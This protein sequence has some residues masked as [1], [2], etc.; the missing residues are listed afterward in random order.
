ME[1]KLKEIVSL[2]KYVREIDYSKESLTSD[3]TE[4]IV[5]EIYPYCGFSVEDV[6]PSDVAKF[7]KAM[8]EG[9]E[10]I[11]FDEE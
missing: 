9:W 4:A 6:R 5:N 10:E 7:K 8:F 3:E 2:S 1:Y 11:D